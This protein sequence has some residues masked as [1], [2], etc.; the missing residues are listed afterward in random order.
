MCA[1]PSQD[2][3]P[4]V[5]QI[6]DPHLCLFVD[7]AVRAKYADAEAAAG[8]AVAM[9]NRLTENLTMPA[10]TT[11]AVHLCRRAGGKARGEHGT[12]GSN[13]HFVSL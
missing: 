3:P 1:L 11:L 7:D 2:N 13:S 5:L 8:F 10:G 4:A 12:L 6:D 9:T